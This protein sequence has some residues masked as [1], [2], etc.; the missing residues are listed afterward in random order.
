M[1][2]GKDVL[3]DSWFANLSENKRQDLLG[4]LELDLDELSDDEYC[5]MLEPYYDSA[6]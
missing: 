2:K 1:K 6:N 3:I 5:G 4:A